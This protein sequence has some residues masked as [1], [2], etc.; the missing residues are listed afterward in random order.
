MKTKKLKRE[1]EEEE[2]EELINHRFIA[3]P[4]PEN[5][6]NNQFQEDQTEFKYESLSKDEEAQFYLCEKSGI[7]FYRGGSIKNKQFY[8]IRYK[9]KIVRY[10]VKATILPDDKR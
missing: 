5:T 3:D 7:Q 10:E 6:R 1:K 9:T 2:N 4:E 8:D